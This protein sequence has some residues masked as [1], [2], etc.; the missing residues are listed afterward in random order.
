VR[1]REQAAYRLGHLDT[2][3]AFTDLSGDLLGQIDRDALAVFTAERDQHLALLADEY[4]VYTAD[5]RRILDEL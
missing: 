4:D 3:L 2:L 5:A 1:P